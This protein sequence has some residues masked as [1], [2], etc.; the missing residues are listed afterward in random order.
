MTA[1][2]LNPFISDDSSS[3]AQENLLAKESEYI[4][5]AVEAL[6]LTKNEM[7]ILTTEQILKLRRRDADGQHDGVWS[8]QRLPTRRVVPHPSRPSKLR[9]S[10]FRPHLEF[11]PSNTAL[12]IT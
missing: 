7:V 5:R 3:D 4:A 2:D 1:K 12:P 8:K 6:K 9:F 10:P 11:P